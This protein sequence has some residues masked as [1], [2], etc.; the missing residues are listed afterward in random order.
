MNQLETKTAANCQDDDDEVDDDD[1]DDDGD[2]HDE[3]DKPETIADANP[4]R[5]TRRTRQRMPATEAEP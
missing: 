4:H 1:N 2:D 5:R 3:D